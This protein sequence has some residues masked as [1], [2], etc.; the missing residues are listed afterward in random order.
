MF[1][2][3]A[4]FPGNGGGKAPELSL[5]VRMKEFELLVGFQPPD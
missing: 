2:G 5:M 3:E 1:P 4:A